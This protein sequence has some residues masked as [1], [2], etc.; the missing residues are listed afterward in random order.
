MALPKDAE[1]RKFS[2]PPV[3]DIADRL[4]IRT[5]NLS[6]FLRNVAS[7]LADTGKPALALKMMA[8][9]EEADSEQ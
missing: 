6:T 7:Q 3:G 9:A 8:A 1:S 2:L 4:G 5:S